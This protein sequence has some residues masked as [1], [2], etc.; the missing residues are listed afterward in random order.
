MRLAFHAASHPP[1]E[2][3]ADPRT[4]VD[5]ADSDAL[6]L[7]KGDS[8]HAN[9]LRPLV[10]VWVFDAVSR[11]ERSWFATISSARTASSAT[12]APAL[13]AAEWLRLGFPVAFVPPITFTGWPW[14]TS[15][16][17]LCFS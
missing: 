8:L 16:R 4:L 12:L 2:Y 13:N 6:V 5:H 1:D 3:V 15:R 17:H 10:D 9:E 11:T 7:S 14:P